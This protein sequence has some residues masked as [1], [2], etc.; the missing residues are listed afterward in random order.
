MTDDV[1]LLNKL[2]TAALLLKY[3][4]GIRRA[5]WR[6]MGWGA[7]VM[8][9]TMWPVIRD[10]EFT[11]S[12]LD[13]VSLGLGTLLF[14][15]G[16]YLVRNQEPG[17]MLLQGFSLGTLALFYIGFFALSL[18]TG[19]NWGGHPLAGIILAIASFNTF[20]SYYPFSLI[21]RDVDTTLIPYIERLVRETNAP[22]NSETEHNL[23]FEIKE[24]MGETTGWRCLLGKEAG[25][26]ILGKYKA[27]SSRIIPTEYFFAF[28]KD[29]ILESVGETWMGNKKKVCL[30]IR[31][32]RIDGIVLNPT[33]YERLGKWLSNDL[34]TENYPLLVGESFSHGSA[35][36]ITT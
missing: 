15:V 27:F 17:A 16:I 12:V 20:Q 9:L 32:E 28:R 6:S 31:G 5:G 26:F 1:E 24:T 30:H 4:H 10:G 21:Y 11:T 35:N 25:F 8:T 36:E 2:N 33:M 14:I 7:L 34:S 13:I 18:L 23:I 3:N 29:I 22:T 19:E